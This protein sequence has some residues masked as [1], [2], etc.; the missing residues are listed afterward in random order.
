MKPQSGSY[1]ENL[2]QTIRQSVTLKLL[3]IF[4]MMMLLL[5][6]VA[7]I[8]SLI[9]ERESLR[10][11]TIREVSGQWANEQTVYGPILTIPLQRKVIEG[12]QVTII[13]N[14]AHI[15]P[16]RLTVEGS[17]T[18]RTLARGIYEVVVYDSQLSFS[19]QFT[20]VEETLKGLKDYEAFPE[21]AFLTIHISDLRGIKEKVVVNWNNQARN[22]VPGTNIPGLASSGITIKDILQHGSNPTEEFSFALQLQ[23][24]QY[25]GF[26]PLGKETV[27]HL[28]SE[29]KAPS[30]TGSFLPEDRNL[31][32]EGFAAGWKVLELN[33]NYPQFWV[34]DRNLQEIQD[35]SFGVNLLLPVDDYQKAM[36]S[37]KYALLAISLTFLTFFLV[38]IFNHNR[39]HPF[40]Y[41]LIGLALTLFYILLV[42][43]SE[44]SSFD[45]A[46][47]ISSAA[48][49][50]MI[51]LYARAILKKTKPT[52]TLVLILCAT[53]AFVYV[54]LQVQDY[55]L[56]IG[57]IGLTAILA[58]TMYITR[59]INWYE[60]SAA[61]RV[62]GRVEQP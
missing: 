29:W 59:N 46:Y 7:I 43:I 49:I 40:Q 45:V 30:F 6:P 5:I 32:E 13:H 27:V 22:V 3:S 55:A 58:F 37:A 56:I 1:L 24:S 19:G 28:D 62:T 14:Q 17:V 16:S 25:L 48:I 15:L 42:A 47:L 52:L 4:I 9:Q 20:E 35:S 38:E 57:S 12:D 50:S 2:S 44:H 26:L 34:G 8:K 36:R 11:Q 33:R 18:P 60:L 51:G 54:T 21:E 31:S 41:I 53:Y 39:L 10:Q 61:E 23:G